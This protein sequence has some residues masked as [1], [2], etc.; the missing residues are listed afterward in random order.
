MSASVR[1][2]AAIG[3]MAEAITILIGWLII[4]P[5]ARLTLR[6]RDR[7]VVI[8]RDEGKFVDNAKYF[9]LQAAHT[10]PPSTRVVF[11][12]ERPD[13]LALLE[14]HSLEAVIHPSI[15]SVFF[16]LTASVAV[17]DSTEWY[18]RW[19]RFLLAGARVVQL[20]HGVGYKRIEID[21][22]SN[23]AAGRGWMSMPP[24][25]A[26][27]S[28][29]R[30]LT[31]R[32]VT[33]AVVNTTSAFYRDR[34][35]V[36]AFKSRHFT[37]F[38]YPRNAFGRVDGC[39]LPGS[40]LNV[41]AALSQRLRDWRSGQRRIVLVT[42]TYR[43]SRATPLGLDDEAIEKLD[44]YA[45]E[46]GI[47]F[48]FKF[49]PLERGARSIRGE[50]LHLCAPESDLYPLMPYSDALVTDY[51]SIYVDYLL[52]GKPVLFL[53]PDLD[54][55]VRLDRQLQFDFDAMTPG[56]KVRTWP[57]LLE[58]LEKEWCDDAFT[59]DRAALA[60]T[61]FDGLPQDEAVPKLLEFMRVRGWIADMRASHA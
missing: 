58:Q 17:V 3:V 39:S 35:F 11:L 53:V 36:P 20:W 50:H 7:I 5:I 18:L 4:W 19:R 29:R 14:P 32:L 33:Y 60:R 49:H 59:A 31:G 9:Y 8:G 21:K 54:A 47:E 42:P 2:H 12:T 44:F 57:E 51:S 55:Y 45:A 52:L 34:V 6:R 26:L 27:R 1:I 40:E 28:L 24:I 38:G 10:E 25:A 46:H 61:A 22:W 43:D 13:V 16:L 30:W 37:V 56:A 23:E 41:D 48:V 15:H